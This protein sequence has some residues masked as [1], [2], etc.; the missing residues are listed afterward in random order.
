[1]S[2]LSPVFSDSISAQV[3]SGAKEEPEDAQDFEFSPGF[4]K[5]LSEFEK[6]VSEFES[7]DQKVPPKEPRKG[8]ASPQLSESD[9]EFY[10]CR[11]TF[12]DF[13]DAEDVKLDHEVIYRISEP[14]SPMP[15]SSLDMTLVK[16]GP[17]LATHP[18]L[19][20]EDYKRF[21][22]GSESLGEFAYDSEGSRECQAEGD[23]PV[24]EELPSRDQA[25]YYDDDDFLGREIEEEL[26]FL[27]SDS[28]EEEVVTTRVVRRRVI[29][30]A[31]SLPDIPP[32]TVTEEKYTDEHGNMVVKKITRKVIRKFVSPDGMETQ[33]VT[34]EG[35]HQE[36]V[37]I[38]EGDT[39]SRVVKRTVLHS[40]GDQK[41][42]TFSEPPALG[43]A[44]ASEF[45]VEPVQGRKVSKVVKTTVVRGERME[46]QIGDPSLA[47]DL[48]SA[49]EDFEKALS[50]AGGFGKVLLPHVV[51]KEI[52]QDDGSVVKR[53]QMRKSRTQ[54]RTVVRDAQGKHVHL[55]RLDDTPDA[56]QPDALQQHLHLLLQRYCED[57]QDEEEEEEEEDEEEGEESEEEHFD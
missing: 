53:S 23:L 25:G 45:E 50:Y 37:Q 18:F 6:T 40:G 13:S 39:V 24:C 17:R 42:L 34:I 41:E 55:E 19:H 31:D 8:S 51:E 15:G 43:A 38:E 48:P 30:Q 54:K 28:S 4:Q 16:G 14:P 12:S 20:V 52:I 21:S 29:I 36:T 11:Q 2:P 33:E 47:A 10:D 57:D 3:T 1:M 44:T 46:K 9:L 22:S 56:L 5:V 27:S 7:E 35:S 49:R 32:Q 26:G